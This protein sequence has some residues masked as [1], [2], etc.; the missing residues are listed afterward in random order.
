M[1]FEPDC[2][3]CF[4]W[5]E[6]IGTHCLQSHRCSAHSISF[7][8]F[9]TICDWCLVK[10]SL[11]QNICSLKK[12]SWF[13]L[14]FILPSYRLMIQLRLWQTQISGPNTSTFFP[15]NMIDNF[16]LSLFKF[17]QEKNVERPK[18]YV[19]GLDFFSCGI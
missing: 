18:T 10:G 11:F 14:T 4:S 16:M 12:I 19:Y 3:L 9:R 6:M 5:T 13:F 1:I 7:W 17:P 8:W 15:S 2:L